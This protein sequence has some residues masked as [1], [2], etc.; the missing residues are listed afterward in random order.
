MRQQGRLAEWNDERGFGFIT[1][2]G[3]GGRH[4]VH[5]S[6]FPPG[7]RPVAQELVSFT[8][9]RD[10]RNRLRAGEVE[11]LERGK[12]DMMTGQVRLA[13]LVAGVFL[14]LIIVLALAGAVPWLILLVYVALSG[15]SLALYAA[16]KAAAERHAWRTPEASLL[17]LDLLGGWP[18]GLVAQQAF[19]HKTKKQPFRTLFLC[20]VVINLAVTM[21]I[22]LS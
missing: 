5:I 16:D 18:G 11:Y 19:R 7:P 20:T 8:P 10:G 21:V 9:S 17:L 15:L 13:L 4:F 3:G 6:S 22:V 14:A 12:L 2:V 1:P